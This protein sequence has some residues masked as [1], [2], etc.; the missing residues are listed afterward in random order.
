MLEYLQGSVSATA[1]IHSRW[2]TRLRLSPVA[3][4]RT[5][6]EERNTVRL[7][8]LWADTR[9]RFHNPFD[10]GPLEN[11]KEFLL[12]GGAEGAVDWRSA[13]I[14]TVMD[15]EGHPLR[16]EME[17]RLAMQQQPQPTQQPQQQQPQPPVPQQVPQLQTQTQAQVMTVACPANA[18][19]GTLVQIQHPTSGGAFQVAVPAGVAPGQAFQVQLPAM[20]APPA[21]AAAAAATQAPAQMPAS[22]GIL[23]G[24]PAAPRMGMEMPS[25][26]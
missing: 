24:P 11:W 15:I 12:G 19:P 4:V 6:H 5:A 10:K 14:F 9:K 20:P 18:A 1:T 22:Y 16:E 3:A 17:R 8:Y 2:T 13:R 7:N 25:E 26:P 21:Q 23:S